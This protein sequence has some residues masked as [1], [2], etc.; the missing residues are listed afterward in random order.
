MKDFVPDFRYF[1]VQKDNVQPGVL[2]CIVFIT[3][4]KLHSVF[5]P[6][7]FYKRLYTML[8]TI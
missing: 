3:G 5:F 1:S 2:F 7:K 6:L 4:L 8:V